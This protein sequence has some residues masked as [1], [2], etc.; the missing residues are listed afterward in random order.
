[1]ERLSNGILALFLV[2]D[3]NDFQL[4]VRDDVQSAATRLGYDLEVQIAQGDPI[5]QIR[6]LYAC[7]HRPP[8]TRPKALL[9]IPVRDATL[10]QM[11]R[12]AIAANMGCVILNRHPAYMAA[13]RGEF[14]KV[15]LG[16][17]GPDQVEAGRLQG[18][19]ARALLP[20]GGFVLY[21]MGPSLSSATQDRLAGLTEE[22]KGSG[23]DLAQVHGDWAA[24][25]AEK[26][27]LRWLRLV[28]Q[29]ELRLD[30]VVC[31]ND[32][33]AIG[34]RKA[35]QAAAVELK[36]PMLATLPMTGFDG[37]PQVGRKMVDVGELAGTIVQTGPG[38]PA[39]Q[40]VDRALRGDPKD[41]QVVLPLTPYPDI[42]R[43][44]PVRR[45]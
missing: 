30:L 32:A 35:L 33:M 43:L 8:E 7:I 16:T 21:V 25:V 40:W 17:V 19:Q 15:A 22:L 36:Q 37:H 23:I 29:S 26:A 24:A 4:S 2:N 6:Q 13:L 1:M 27:V 3:N 42:G 45:Q 44:R 20:N 38:A 34:A 39:V 41:P 5:A 11:V 31:Q 12:D 28:L 14:P 18:R 9:L 10:E